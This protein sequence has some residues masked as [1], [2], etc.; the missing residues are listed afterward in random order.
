MSAIQHNIYTL[1]TLWDNICDA[2]FYTPPKE[3]GGSDKIV[4][5]VKLSAEQTRE[6]V[7]QTTRPFVEYPLEKLL[8]LRYAAAQQ[9][10]EDLVMNKK[11]DDC[12]QQ[13]QQTTTPTTTTEQHNDKLK[14]D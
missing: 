3:L 6:Q 7:Y 14:N 10:G 5:K 12:Q 4:V 11:K 2:L 8:T 1:P 9:F 13:V